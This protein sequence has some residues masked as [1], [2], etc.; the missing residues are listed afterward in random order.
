[1][2]N[3][4]KRFVARIVI[5]AKTPLKVG[6]S[7]VDMLQDAPIQKDFNDLPMILGTSLAGVLRSHFDKAKAN[8]LFGDEEKENS[9]KV[10]L[11]NA[12]LLDENNQVHEELLLEKSDFLKL[13][14]NLPI[15]DHTAITDKGVAKENSKFDEEVVYTGSRFAF[16]LEYMGDDEASF[17]ELIKTVRSDS[18]RLGGGTTKGF[19]DVAIVEELSSYDLFDVTSKEY[20][21]KS[22]SLNTTYAKPL[23]KTE[24]KEDGYIRYE[25][26]LTSD[27]FFMFGSGFGDDDADTTPVYEQVINYEKKG[28]SERKVV[29]PASSIKGALSHRTAYHYNKQN[30][31]FV[32]DE[33]ARATIV[34]I[35][36]EAK[37]ESKGLKGKILFSDCYLKK[38]GEKVFDHVSIDRFTGG[39]IEGALFQEKT[40]ADVETFTIEILLK[41]D[42]EDRYK[43]ALEA[44]L[45]DITTGMLPLGGATTKGHGVF[46]G[47]VFKNGEKL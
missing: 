24:K 46:S 37:E 35:F 39:A 44:A 13:F 11:S 17:F 31:Y 32:G 34:E 8:E 38:S 3:S 2:A 22:S 45:T 40:V 23:P 26:K 43:E 7:D 12:L 18:F 25:L 47:N 6:S 10:I 29:I 15:R 16:R 4:N 1:M 21:Q 41:N 28:L 33:K 14:E 36:G 9:S 5:E 27:D 20:A 30:G 19:G 42:V